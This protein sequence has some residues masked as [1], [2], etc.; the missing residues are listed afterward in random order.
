MRL[1]GVEGTWDARFHGLVEAVADNLAEGLELGMSLA[2]SVAG[3]NVVDLWGGHLDAARTRPWERDSLVCVFSCT[4][5]V[6]AMATMWAVERGLV[7]LDAPV[8]SY[9]PEFAAEGKGEL[10]VRWLLT[11]EAGLPAI[12]QR[13]PRGS[14][15]D[16]D[17]MTTALAAQAPSWEPGT[18]HGYHGV[19]YGHLIGEVLRRATG[20]TCGALIRDEL[21]GP[22]GV[23]LWMPLPRERDADTADLVVEMAPEGTF[24]DAWDP[25]TSLGP[26][27]F[28]NPPDSNDPNHCMTD[29]WRRAEIPAAN[30]HSNARALDRLYGVLATG[31]TSGDLVLA[32]PALVEEFGRCHV[33]GDDR[34]MELPTA[35]GLGFEHTIPEWP[36]GPG[37]RTY[38][39][40]GS[41]GSLGFVDPD[42]GVSVG[43]AMNRLWWGAD[44][45]DP[46]WGRMFAELYAVL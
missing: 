30:M 2:V 36:F 29:Q 39:H 7:D 45:T 21:A 34:V 4:K 26:R 17:A 15:S 20:R 5:G 22:L 8:A 11:H 9:W 40:N 27:A 3:R 31:G 25:K 37:A 18:A 14:L 16:W 33:V 24:F 10:P 44:R 35:F 6:V 23:E 42:A 1:P 32:S 43:Y 13:M 28:G 41:G 38:G 19:T 12:G 46:R